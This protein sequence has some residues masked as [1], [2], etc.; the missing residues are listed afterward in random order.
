MELPRTYTELI[1]Q[2]INKYKVA[3]RYYAERNHWCSNARDDLHYWCAEDGR[4]PWEV[5][6]EI[7]GYTDREDSSGTATE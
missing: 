4:P 6:E 5:A 2:A 7:V 1:D 3:L